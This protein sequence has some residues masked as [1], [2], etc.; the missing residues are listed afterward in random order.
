M[1][2]VTGCAGFI[3]SHVTKRLLDAGER[4]VGVDNLNDAYDPELKRWR[5]DELSQFD[6]FSLVETDV[7]EMGS[8]NEIAGAV[9]RR[10]SRVDAVLNLA[11]RAGVQP[12]VERPHDYVQTNIAGALNMMDLCRKLEVRK[13]VMASS[14]SVYSD[15][16]VS[17]ASED[18]PTDRPLSPYAASKKAAEA[19]AYTYHHLHGLDVSVLRYFSVY[20]PAGRPDM[21]PLRFVRGIA[22]GHPLALF[23][24]GSQ[25]RDFTYVD[26]IARGTIDALRPVGFEAFNLGS[27]S[28]VSISAFISII[29][30]V[31][32]KKAKINRM[33]AHRADVRATW[34]DISK[35]KKLLRWSPQ[36]SLRQ[37]IQATADWYFANRAFVDS[38]DFGDIAGS[39]DVIRRNAA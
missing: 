1:H 34:A 24:D 37:G 27:D 7:A 22:S 26:D 9:A 3:A 18:S 8:V 29:E 31:V 11:A 38:L 5:L 36:V 35:A 12:S 14:S 10:G 16:S 20:G 28:P 2:I 30:D 13:F 23:G 25:E 32:G 19:F 15:S 6:Q 4:V 17:P 33:P 39:G 21:A